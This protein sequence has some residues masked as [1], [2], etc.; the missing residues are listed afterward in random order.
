MFE[1]SL[2]AAALSPQS[3]VSGMKLMKNEQQLFL[4]GTE[5]RLKSQMQAASR[6]MCFLYRSD[7]TVHHAC[8][9][10]PITSLLSLFIP[11]YWLEAQCLLV[12]GSKIDV[13]IAA[14]FGG[15]YFI[16]KNV[17]QTSYRI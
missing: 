4:F 13:K 9:E 15:F 7:A 12:K 14:I 6:N 1:E 8:L 10:C 3:K 5:G 16:F 17:F 11:E 2:V